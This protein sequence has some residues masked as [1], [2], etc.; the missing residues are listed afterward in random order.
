[1]DSCGLALDLSP[2]SWVAGL[3][4]KKHVCFTDKVLFMVF[5][6]RK[7]ILN[8]MIITKFSENLLRFSLVILKCFITV[9]NVWFHSGV[10]KKQITVRTKTV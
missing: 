2:A 6:V 9:V 7:V 5:M 1:M 4:E 10:Y 3:T 8:K